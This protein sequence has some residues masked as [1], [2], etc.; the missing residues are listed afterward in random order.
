M[1]TVASAPSAPQLPPD[2]RP[3]GHAYARRRPEQTS[4]YAVVRDNLRTLYAA[5]ED[6]FA[7]AAL[8]DFVRKDLAG[9]PARGPPYLKSRLFR[10]KPEP[11]D[12]PDLWGA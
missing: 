2:L 7:G 9:Y 4:L 3:T 8:P 5:V 10:R 12:Q 6:G 11:P 1:S